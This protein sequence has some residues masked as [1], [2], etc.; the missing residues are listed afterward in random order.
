MSR[1]YQKLDIAHKLI[2]YLLF[3]VL[4][5]EYK[6]TNE[7]FAIKA[8]KKGD[9]VARDEVDRSVC[10]IQY[11]DY[12]KQLCFRSARNTTVSST[13]QQLNSVKRAKQAVSSLLSGL[14]QSCGLSSGAGREQGSPGIVIPFSAPLTM[15]LLQL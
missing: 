4:L 3:Q 12:I 11:M 2:A 5:A 14:L 10:K 13:K 1:L 9:I 6:N 7:M 15:P 8:L